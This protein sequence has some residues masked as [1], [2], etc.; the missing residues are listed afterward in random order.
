MNHADKA[1]VKLNRNGVPGVVLTA[2]KKSGIERRVARAMLVMDHSLTE[3]DGGPGSGNHNHAGRPGHRGGSAKGTGY[4]T[5]KA[6]SAR[7]A[8][9]AAHSKVSTKSFVPTLARA[10]ASQP[11]DRAWRVDTYRTADDFD[12]ENIQTFATG[13]GSTFAIKP[14]GDIISVCKMA[15]DGISARSL[16]AAAV[17]QGGDHL[18]SYDGNFYFYQ[19]C[20]FEVVSRCKFDIK[21][22]P[23]GW[24]ESR[25]RKEDVIFMRY[26]GVGNVRDKSKMAMQRRVPYSE[27]YDAAEA[28][29]KK[30]MGG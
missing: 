22:K 13:G 16:L 19:A 7:V 26:V 9:P 24:E 8:K 28:V 10:K 23:P 5:A 20:G 3:V 30:V 12:T 21:Y 4:S 14:D 6:V 17:E 2:A 27:D 29:L 11:E 25:D 18:D 1:L 15:G